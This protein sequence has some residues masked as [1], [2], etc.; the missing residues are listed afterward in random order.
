MAPL[1][2]RRRY[3]S[4]HR[5]TPSIL[6]TRFPHGVSQLHALDLCPCFF[7]RFNHLT[8]SIYPC[9]DLDR[10]SVP[11][12]VY[13]FQLSVHPSVCCSKYLNITRADTT[14][15]ITSSLPLVSYLARPLSRLF[16]S[17]FFFFTLCCGPLLIYDCLIWARLCTFLLGLSLRSLSSGHSQY[18][19]KQTRHLTPSLSFILSL[20][21]LLSLS[22]LTLVLEP[23]ALYTRDLT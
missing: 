5:S 11:H 4:R 13:M 23:S 2:P 3:L 22:T 8:W 16:F 14:R 9:S 15:P 10:D 20:L 6:Y 19:H 18:K 1:I 17:S 12:H 21:L 7:A